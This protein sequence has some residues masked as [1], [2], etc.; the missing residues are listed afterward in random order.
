[1]QPYTTVFLRNLNRLAGGGHLPFLIAHDET[2]EVVSRFSVKFAFQVEA[3]GE[4]SGEL[5]FGVVQFDFVLLPVK[6][7]AIAIEEGEG[8]QD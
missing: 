3:R 8:R 4:R 1:M 2:H 6:V 5:L 7:F